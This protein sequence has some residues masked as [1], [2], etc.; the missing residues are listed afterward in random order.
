MVKKIDRGGGLKKLGISFF[1]TCSLLAFL[2]TAN[3][4]T[5]EF[6]RPVDHPPIPILDEDGNHVLE[7]KNPYSPK[8]TCAG[9]GC[10]DYEKITHAYHFQQGRDETSDD[11]GVKRGLPHLVGPGYFGGYTCMGGSNPQVLA[12]K[13]NASEDEFYDY[14]APGWV[15]TCMSCHVGGGW[16]ERDRDG[17]RY[18]EKDLSQVKPLDGDY[19]ERQIDP[20]TGE[21]VIALWD[22]KKSGVGEGDCLFCH[23]DFKT[24]K[25]PE[26]SGLEE[27]L[28][29][30][31]ARQAFT[32]RDYFRQAASGFMEYVVDNKGVNLMTVARSMPA[33]DGGDHSEHGGGGI[34]FTFNDEHMPIFN[35]HQEAFDENGRTV[36]PMIRFPNNENCMECHLT[37]NS[38]RGFYGFGEVAS[39]TLANAGED[40][41]DGVLEDDYQDDVHKGKTFTDDT[42]ETRDIENCNACHSKQYFKSKL[43]NVDLDANHDFMKG[44]SDNDVRNDLDYAPNAKSC[45]YCHIQV[46]SP[47]IPSGHDTLLDAHIELWKGN[48]D[49]AGYSAESLQQI[50]QTHFDVV[51]CQTCHINGKKSR[52]VDIQLMYRYRIAENGDSTM[53]PYNPRLRYFWQDKVSGRVL[54]KNER[55]SV[56]E[57]GEDAEG[58]V[59]GT[60]KDPL[61]GETLGQVSASVGRHGLSYGDPEDYEGFVALKTAYDN[62][63]IKKGYSAPDTALIWSESN[64]YIIS[65]NTRP[66]PDSV[67]C[68]ECHERKQS[69]AFSSLVSPQ[70]ILGEANEKLV[71][72]IPDTRLVDDGII[73]LGLSYMKLQEN[74]DITQNVGDILFETKIDPFMSLFKNSSASET[75]GAFQKF[76]TRDVLNSVGPGLRSK[77]AEGLNNEDSFVYQ[78][79]KGDISLRNMAAAIDGNTINSLLF[80]TYRGALG[81]LVGAEPAAQQIM[82][83]RG[84]GQLRSNVFYFDV[85]DSSKTRVQD[86]NGEDLY[87]LMPYK[88]NNTDVNAI[89]LVMANWDVTSIKAL[90]ADQILH[91]VPASEVED[92]FIVFKTTETGY[93]VIGDK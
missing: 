43:A 13:D 12:K 22:W 26:D 4:V 80:P 17:V 31:R 74:G 40:S 33:N 79:A 38:R 72:T 48:G 65:H 85:I 49:M 63:L 86:F 66:S 81:M 7:T 88:G 23:V 82:N 11:Y 21:E 55:L 90:S 93:F 15:R 20:A 89:N 8:Q 29:P 61:S 58:N 75:I 67:Q 54:V 1:L 73:V 27:P 50:T 16:A 83:E 84:Y 60:I 3:A 62:L 68:E 36:I 42:G 14:G 35:W 6:D 52:G 45:E 46:K 64:E 10:H 9:S 91:I 34:D 41:A 39:A 25:L 5:N 32:T 2:Q 28:S 57:Q 78:V 18:D 77:L 24:L 19:Y 69:G 70:G 76:A 30:R 92:G 56:F 51:A 44:N 87:M 59:F 47:I 37:S 53:V 71:T